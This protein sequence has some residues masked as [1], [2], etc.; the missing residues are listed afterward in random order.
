MI[1]T[2]SVRLSGMMFLEF[3]VKALW[4]PIAGAILTSEVVKGGM[5]FSEAQKGW[6]M[7]LPMAAGAF[8]SP[9]IGSLCDRY[10]NTERCLAVLLFC[11]GILKFATAY[12]TSFTAWILLSTL[13]GMCFIPTVSLTNSLAMSH[14]K[15]AS[16]QFGRIRL[17]GT[18]GW[19]VA[20][21]SFP[22]IW[23]QVDLEFQWL[24]PFLKGVERPDAGARLLDSFK[25]AGIL[26]V[27][28]SFYAWFGLPKTPPKNET[29]QKFA[30]AQALALFRKRSFTVLLLI[31]IPVSVL[32]AIYFIQDASF[33]RVSGLPP[34]ELGWVM[35]IGQ[36]SEIAVLALMG[37]GLKRI[38]FKWIML[39]GILFH[40]LR[41]TLFSIPGLGVDAYIAFQTIHGLCY[42]GF[43]A[44][45]W[46][47]VDRV[48]PVQ[49]RHSAQ[50]L[51]FVVMFGIAPLITG[52]INS[53]LAS[54]VGADGEMTPAQYSGYW[55]WAS[56]IGYAAAVLF[57]L[58]FREDAVGEEAGGER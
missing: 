38:G 14:L 7:V 45:A 6:I 13:Y 47:Y 31:G 9:V 19:I 33:L 30:L 15:D 22:M 5:G 24:P 23:L 1:K 25:I 54:F 53:G 43:F 42:A 20:L 37:L 26:A 11:A 46:I 17:W 40:A 27:L 41:Y 48:A 57:F 4:Y 3:A 2:P 36:F 28:Y 12:Q 52:F 35:S 10:V 29:G 55:T 39:L 58:L 18:I 8:F 44:T 21:W 32:N 56:L 51:F 49:A 34:S 16:K 50:T